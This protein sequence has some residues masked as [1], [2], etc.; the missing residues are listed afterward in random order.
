LIGTPL[1][2]SPEQA[3]FSGVD[4]DT[5]SDI[6]SLGVLLYELLTGTTPFD[7]ETFRTAGYDEI[8]RIIREEE[9][10]KPS[11]RLRKDEGGMMKDES[12]ATNQ[13]GWGR[14][15]P[16][17]SFILHPSSF[18]ELDWIVMKCLEKDRNRRYETAN[19][20]VADLRRHLN[21]EPVTACPPSAWYRLRK[22]ARRNRAILATVSAVA[23]ALVLT[24]VGLAVSNGLIRSE[25]RKTDEKAE[26]VRRHDYI[27]R[28]NL[29]YRECRANN[30]AQALE[31]LDGCPEDLRGWEWSYVSRQCHL[32]LQTFQEPAPS[33]NAVAFSPDGRYLA[34]GSGHYGGPYD[35][36]AGGESGDLVVREVA[37]GREV[38]A[39]RGLKGSIRALAFSPDGRW[40]AVGL[41]TWPGSHHSEKEL[42]DF[43]N[44]VTRKSD[45]HPLAV[46]P[47]GTLTL[48]DAAT[49]QER[50]HKT[51]PGPLGISSLAFSPDS[52][53]II[54]GYANSDN[55]VGRRPGHAKVWDVQTGDVLID[56]IP[57]P[58]I[59]VYSVA[60]SPDG[61][62]AALAGNGQVDV[63]DLASQRLVRSLSGHTHV[64]CAVAWSPDGRYLASGGLDKT[65][66]L[67]DSTT[68]TELWNYADLASVF[69]LAFSPDGRRIASASGNGLRLWWVPSGAELASFHGHQHPV[70]CVAFSPD[71]TQLASGSSDQTIKL[72]FAT[73]NL[74][75]SIRNPHRQVRDVAFS[76]DG[77]LVAS[78]WHSGDARIW[79]PATG[80]ERLSLEVPSGCGAIAWSPDGRRLATANLDHHAKVWDAT[81][82]RMLLTLV[83]T[84]DTVKPSVAFSPD[85]RLLAQVDS[86]LSVK[87]WDATTGR[88]VHTLRGHSAAVTVVAFSPN[89]QTLASA[90]DDKTV[91]IWDVRTG[92][93]LRTLQGH[94]AS[95]YGLAFSPDGRK[96]AS[97]GGSMRRLG[98]VRVWDSSTGRELAQLQE[99]TERLWCVAFSPDGLRLATA[100]DDLTIK[101]WDTSTGQEVFALRGHATAVVCLAFSPDGRRIVSGSADGTVN[102][103]DLDPSRADVLSRRDAV[104]LASSGESFLKAGRWDQAAAALSRALDLRLDNARL[105][106]ARGRAF[107]HLGQ[108]QKA[109]ADFAQALKLAKGS[110][111]SREAQDLGE[112]FLEMGRWEAAAA[113]LSR[114]L[115]LKL[116]SAQLRAARDRAFAR[117][118]QARQ[119][120]ADFAQAVKLAET[121]FA[122]SGHEQR[123]LAFALER[124]A[125]QLAKADAMLRE[126]VKTFEQIVAERPRDVN[127]LHF[128]ADTHRRLAQVLSAR[129]QRDAALA[130]YREAIRLHEERLV[131]VPDPSFGESERV[132]AYFEYARLLFQVERVV[133]ARA[134]YDQAEPWLRNWLGTVKATSGPASLVYAGGLASLGLSL[135]DR[136]KWVDAE[137]VL[138]ECLALREKQEPDA[139]STFNTRSMLGEALVGQK[140]RAEAE[141]LLVEG[142][143][144]MKQRAAKIPIQGKPRLAEA[145]ERLVELYDAWGKPDQATRWRRELE[146]ENADA[147]RPDQSSRTK[148]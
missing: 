52:G 128:A 30:V 118:G 82:G 146:R 96:I 53:R 86:D 60:F 65:L 12:K 116:D 132:A 61:K 148:E 45:A 78:C 135:L 26:A 20:L 68:G 136:K 49:G 3:E 110:T 113:A 137:P 73:P 37:T 79:D 91:K 130:E 140:K 48:W 16:F 89:G 139:W 36:A 56:R 109:E 58:G 106:L 23:A 47:A 10:P 121:E 43:S 105:R 54:A 51:D 131:R 32:E 74:Q 93:E 76:P 141:P 33:V 31:L 83:G 67:W 5:R 125:G 41:A 9:P 72:W 50:F 123:L 145:L 46:E 81:T 28:V 42:L 94:V 133:E 147:K 70:Y 127:G 11:T 101:L 104:A 35:Y 8:R 88:R 21:H 144:G 100:G 124:E 22:A 39:H 134:H 114:A 4:V 7:Q 77:H 75:L 69:G 64:V 34:S 27:S 44:G 95:I 115:E 29:A 98:E 2:M 63:W 143:E 62:Q 6:Y 99:H 90:G 111:S 117:L 107:E 119:A 112:A 71:G 87:V 85:G 57:G 102:V 38:F 19:G 18:Q 126:A 24:V 120:E 92:R 138:R 1:Y 142:Y 25:M 66:R 59:G 103:W 40:V 122:G 108:S 129:G 13:T 17:S 80:E 15:L 55:M 97:V 84:Q 14:L